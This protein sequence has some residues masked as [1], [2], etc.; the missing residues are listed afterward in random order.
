MQRQ[1]AARD[2]AMFP[3]L[4]TAIR[5]PLEMWLVMHEDLRATRRVRLLYDLLV[6]DL[7]HY[8]KGR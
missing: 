2:K 4:Q 7:T 3:V 6:E 5:L 8:V 1:L